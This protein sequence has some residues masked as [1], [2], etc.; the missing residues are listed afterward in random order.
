VIMRRHDIGINWRARMRLEI[1]RDYHVCWARNAEGRG[2]T[3]VSGHRLK[4]Y[5]LLH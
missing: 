2:F 3:F 4:T 5:S 1:H